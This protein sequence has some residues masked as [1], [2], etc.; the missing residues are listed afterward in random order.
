MQFQRLGKTPDVS[1][2]SDEIGFAAGT[3]IGTRTDL[4][5]VITPVKFGILQDVQLD[6]S[7]DLKELTGQGRYAI[8]LAPGKTKIELKAKFARISAKLFNDLYFG[9]TSTATQTLFADSE[10]AT[11]PATS[12][13]TVA[14]ANAAT[15]LSDQGVYFQDNGQ[16]MMATGTAPP[17]VSG[18][19][20]PL[21]EAPG[22]YRFSS[23]DAVKAVAL[24]YTY[25]S[26]SGVQITL[27][28]P[29]M[30]VG[31]S[32]KIVLS[33]AF[34]GRQQNF[35]FNQCQSSKL[36]FP[37]KQDDFTISELD[38]MVSQDASGTIGSINT[39]T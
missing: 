6:F 24:S 18:Q 27:L 35:I 36:S 30:G 11:V 22:V 23:A 31:P 17:S 7:A 33:Q 12:A 28:N 3:L 5:G 37:T 19:Y 2:Y 32:F 20:Q 10:L 25:S 21:T 14:A 9:A 15:F 34:D 8:A 38:F 29:R 16:A 4:A 39:S 13:Y 1:Q 26:T